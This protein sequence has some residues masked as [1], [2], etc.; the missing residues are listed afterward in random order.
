MSKAH[1]LFMFR[2]FRR[3]ALFFLQVC[4]T[5]GGDGGGGM[6]GTNE[7]TNGGICQPIKG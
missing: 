4:D 3:Y 2:R 5:H 1:G 7:D 6:L